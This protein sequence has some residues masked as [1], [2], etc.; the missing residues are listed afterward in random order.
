MELIKYFGINYLSQTAL[1]VP[2]FPLLFSSTIHSSIIFVFNTFSP[3][4]FVTFNSSLCVLSLQFFSPLI[5]TLYTRSRN[6]NKCWDKKWRHWSWKQKSSSATQLFMH[7]FMFQ[8]PP[9]C[10]N[11]LII[12]STFHPPV[13]LFFRINSRGCFRNVVW[14][15][16]ISQWD[17]PKIIESIY[18]I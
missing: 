16:S 13:P 7:S 17:S 4:Y 12:I 9:R 11:S 15:L 2:Y 14:N 5:T 18:S 8:T 1:L 3:R 10:S 6:K